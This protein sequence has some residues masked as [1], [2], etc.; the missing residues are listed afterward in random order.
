MEET[1]PADEPTNNPKPEIKP[2]NENEGKEEE[3]AKGEGE[4]EEK[5]TFEYE[6]EDE[7]EEK[8]VDLYL[9]RYLDAPRSLLN[10][11]EISI[12][13]K[14]PR[15]ANA[16]PESVSQA[17]VQAGVT[18]LIPGS[19]MMRREDVIVMHWGA[20]TCSNTL[21]HDTIAHH[22][23]WSPCIDYRAIG[24]EQYGRL[25]M[26]YEVW[27]AEELIGTSPFVQVLVEP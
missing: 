6:D 12:S 24:L 15:L 3:E 20:H 22:A 23:V 26:Y 11:P 13:L 1:P 21:F 27:R 14:P 9:Q 25:E 4:G 10:L 2:E 7:E 17:Q 16:N 18:V 8:P 19:P 5:Q